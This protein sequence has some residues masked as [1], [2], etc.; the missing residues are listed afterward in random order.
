M[1]QNLII[2]GIP[3]LCKLE[4]KLKLGKSLLG[5]NVFERKP[6]IRVNNNVMKAWQV[7]DSWM[8]SAIPVKA[9]TRD[10]VPG[11]IC[12]GTLPNGLT[13]HDKHGWPTRFFENI[14]SAEQKYHLTGKKGIKMRQNEDRLLDWAFIGANTYNPSKKRSNDSKDSVGSKRQSWRPRGYYFKLL[15][16]IIRPWNPKKFA[17]LI[18]NFLKTNDPFIPFIFSLLKWECL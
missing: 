15:R 3:S 8:H 5:N 16:I 6:R 13:I 4:K 10:S 14:L 9:R 7:C 17:Y 1:S 2:S 11:Q 12:G 18:L